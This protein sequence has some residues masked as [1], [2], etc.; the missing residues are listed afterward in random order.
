MCASMTRFLSLVA[1]ST[2]VGGFGFGV[3]AEEWFDGW[4]LEQRVSRS[5]L[6]LVAQVTNVS[7]LTVVE[8]AKTN[9]GL[10][11]YRF[12]PVERIKGVFSRDELAMSSHDLGLGVEDAGTPPPLSQGQY[13]LLFLVRSGFRGGCSTAGA[14]DAPFLQQVPLLTGPEDPLV[15]MARTVVDIAESRS[16]RELVL[17]IAERLGELDGAATIPLLKSLERRL[18]WAAQTPELSAPLARLARHDSS[19]VRSAALQ[20]IE[21]VLAARYLDVDD[22]A[23]LRQFAAALEDAF[24]A[25]VVETNARVALVRAIGHL[26]DSAP[27]LPWTSDRLVS[28]LRHGRTYAERAAAASALAQGGFE[29]EARAVLEVLETLPLDVKDEP[30]REIVGAAIMLDREPALAL[31]RGRLSESTA[32]GHSPLV[33]I[34]ALGDAVDIGAVPVLLD[35]MPTIS[36]LYNG[37][38]IAGHALRQVA[39]ERCLPLASEWLRHSQ[40]DHR[41][42]AIGILEKLGSRA[43]AQVA[44]PRLKMERHLEIKLRI[45]ALLG[46][47]GIRDGYSIAIEHLADGAHSKLAV[48]ALAAIGDPRTTEV[49]EELLSASE[50]PTWAA[51][52]LE[53]FVALGNKD[54]RARIVEILGDVHDPLFESAVEIS[55][56]LPS[57]PETIRALGALTSS[58]SHEVSTRALRSLEQLFSQLTTSDLPERLHESVAMSA[59]ATLGDPHADVAQRLAALDCLRAMKEARLDDVLHKL[60]DQTGLESTSLLTPI[61]SELRRRRVALRR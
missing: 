7:E 59:A 5:H 49:L 23:T 55:L 26:G 57:T 32:S 61:E 24:A 4:R 8:G 41:L 33:E 25:S 17:Q 16:R 40:T 3:N 14:R 10:R 6:V 38:N 19:A 46:R 27:T 56:R 54:A 2:V 45:A 47:H 31:V 29:G 37:V 50:D 42:V 20:T 36:R 51:S 22:G 52:A 48:E 28:S 34:R 12:Q 39:D 11:E 60:V 13:R 58:R 1:A 30:E 43:A 35:A 44:R 9:T 21:K 18:V 53:T 15:S